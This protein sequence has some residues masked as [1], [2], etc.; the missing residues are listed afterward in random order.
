MKKA[1]PQVPFVP[2]RSD[3]RTPHERVLELMDMT[4]AKTC[5]ILEQLGRAWPRPGTSRRSTRTAAL[6]AACVSHAE[7]EASPPDREGLTFLCGMVQSSQG[8]CCIAAVSYSLA[9]GGDAD[10]KRALGASPA[11]RDVLHRDPCGH[12]LHSPK[13]VLTARLAPERST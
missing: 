4:H 1:E 6:T 11:F 9:K 3:D 13:S 2:Y 7:Y 12:D 8:R 10:G 5:R